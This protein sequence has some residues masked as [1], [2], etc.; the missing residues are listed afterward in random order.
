MRHPLILECYE[1][2][3]YKF[4]VRLQAERASEEVAREIDLQETHP[5]RRQCHIPSYQRDVREKLEVGV[6]NEV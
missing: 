5:L 6:R 3:V 2:V 4:H 1:V